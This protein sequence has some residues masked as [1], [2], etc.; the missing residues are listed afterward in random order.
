MGNS[1]GG[2]AELEDDRGKTTK[3]TPDVRDSMT[4]KPKRVVGR[5]NGIILA[6]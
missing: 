3:S 2:H 4:N 6:L 5:Y 1:N